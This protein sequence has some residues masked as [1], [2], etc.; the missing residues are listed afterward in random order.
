MN[1]PSDVVSPIVAFAVT[2]SRRAPDTTVGEFTR[3]TFWR[4]PAYNCAKYTNK[5]WTTLDRPLERERVLAGS[6][7]GHGEGGGVMAIAR[8]TQPSAAGGGAARG[9]APSTAA[10][11]DEPEPSGV[12]KKAMAAAPPSRGALAAAIVL[13][14]AGGALAWFVYDWVG[15]TDFVPG[16]N[17]AP[18]AGLFVVALALERLLEPF[19]GW[20]LPSTEA[21]KQARDKAVV[22]AV[23]STGRARTMAV[24]VAANKQQQTDEARASRAVLMWAIASVLGM[25]TAAGFGFFLLRSVESPSPAAAKTAAASASGKATTGPPATNHRTGSQDPNRV[26]DLVVTGLVIGAGTKPLHDLVSRIQTANQSSKDPA[27]TTQ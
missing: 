14:A 23:T 2:S 18:L 20:V 22:A 24:Q 27:E 9:S 4:G 15:P 11:S 13:L 10:A 16:S 6:G 1:T 3:L 21:K 17:Y 7:S 25:L 8:F 5:R 26:L 19:S 12:F